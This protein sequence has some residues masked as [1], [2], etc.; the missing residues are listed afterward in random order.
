[1]GRHCA[2]GTAADE[3]GMSRKSGH[4]PVVKGRTWA[5]AVTELAA[6]RAWVAAL[7]MLIIFGAP[8]SGLCYLVVRVVELL[9]K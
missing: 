6:G 8:S 4:P 5:D 7:L 9:R 1:M 2:A 3:H